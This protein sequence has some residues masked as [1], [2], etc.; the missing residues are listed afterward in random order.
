M[1][2]FFALCFYCLRVYMSSILIAAVP[3]AEGETV[4]LELCNISY[5]LANHQGILLILAVVHQAS[6]S[7]RRL[8]YEKCITTVNNLTIC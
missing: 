1:R 6:Q 7:A 5:V 2:P 8:I 3:G 4:L